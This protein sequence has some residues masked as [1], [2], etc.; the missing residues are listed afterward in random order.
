[1]YM[2]V[3]VYIH[4]YIYTHTVVY[5]YAQSPYYD[6]PCEDCLTQI[7]SGDYGLCFRLKQPVYTVYNLDRLEPLNAKY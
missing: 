3:C 5:V 7:I 6:Y 2:Y 1:M 4:I